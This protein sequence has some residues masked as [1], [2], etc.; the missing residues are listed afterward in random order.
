MYMEKF[1]VDTGVYI[2]ILERHVPT[3]VAEGSEHFKGIY[4]IHII[5][6]LSQRDIEQCIFQDMEF[7]CLSGLPAYISVSSENV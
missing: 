7:V 1:K 5:P 4:V 2:K 6:S 3:S